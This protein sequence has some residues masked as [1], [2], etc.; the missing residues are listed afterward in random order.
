ME[1]SI[2]ILI[3]I[4]RLL[5]GMAVAG[6]IL[7][8]TRRLWWLGELACH[9]RMQYLWMSTLSTPVF[10]LMNLVPEL[11]LTIAIGMGN[12]CLILPLYALR[13]PKTEYKGARLLFVNLLFSNR[14]Y[15]RVLRLIKETNPDLIVLQEVN[16][17]WVGALRSL[18]RSYPFHRTILYSGPGGFGIGIWSRLPVHS[19]ELTA[20]GISK[21]PSLVIRYEQEGR[22]ITLIT[23]H[24]LA[25]TSPRQA[26]LRDDHL[27]ELTTFIR[28]QEGPILLIGDL[29]TTS[30]SAAFEDLVRMTRLSDSR[31]GFGVQA[32]WPVA[33]PWA[34]I[35]ID[36]CLVSHEL[37]VKHRRRGPGVGS[38][39]FPIL[40]E[41]ALASN[42]NIAPASCKKTVQY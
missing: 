5:T 33:I 26:W 35:P 13:Q 41:V 23:T 17:R 10:L 29:N 11:S 1:R 2:E 38:D 21:L 40:V 7:A 32:T 18:S 31:K 6:T 34:R 24:P 22:M 37:V 36:H 14:A 4:A 15:G 3:L 27:A 39:H 28:M 16:E 8:C 42:G 12:L 30:W 25:P 20:F 19:N 9:F